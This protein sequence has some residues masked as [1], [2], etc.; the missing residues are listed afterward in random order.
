MRG[1]QG[2]NLLLHSAHFGG[3][4]GSHGRSSDGRRTSRGNSGLGLLRGLLGGRGRGSGGG[5]GY[6]R[7]IS[8]LGNTLGASGG[9]GGLAH[10]TI[11][12]GILGHL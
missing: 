10:C 6:S 4:L 3:G 2:A 12:G 5:G 1:D 7:G 9:G 8:L 11:T